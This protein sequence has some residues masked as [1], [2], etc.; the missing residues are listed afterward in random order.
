ML[1]A[2]RLIVFVP[3][4]AACASAPRQLAPAPGESL[5]LVVPAKGVQIYECRA[6]RDKAAYEWTFVAPHAE[7]FDISGKRIGKHYAGPHWEA[8]DGSTIVG[9]VRA[10]VDAPSAADIPWLLLASKST[11]VEGAF[12]RVTSI[13]RLNT[14]GGVAPKNGCS[15]ARVGEQARVDYTA[16]YYLFA[17][18]PSY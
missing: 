17:R 3:I 11:G 2:L 18:A 6:A 5:Y 10:R 15:Q 4:V 13:Q 12:S 8:A 16:D 14:V 1:R 7:L 9:E